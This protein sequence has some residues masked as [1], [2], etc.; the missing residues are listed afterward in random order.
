MG[1]AEIL[2]VLKATMS[3]TPCKNTHRKMEETA[4]LTKDPSSAF[5]QR[6]GKRVQGQPSPLP[7]VKRRAHTMRRD[8]AHSSLHMVIS[9][10]MKA[11]GFLWSPSYFK[12]STF[13]F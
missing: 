4:T 3:A 9:P 6:S 7:R 10:E 8:A 5:A 13:D 11:Q 1:D 12:T 2:H